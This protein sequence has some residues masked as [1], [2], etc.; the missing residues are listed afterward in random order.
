[1]HISTGFSVRIFIPTGEPDGLRVVEK[2]N[3][4]GQGLV[5]PK[6][7]F[8]DARQRPELQRTGV[9]IMW[10]PGETGQMPQAYIGE[11]D[12]VIERL[13]SHE[14]KKDFWTQAAV[15]TSKDQYLNKAHVQHLEARLVE[16][17]HEAKRCELTNGNQP[18][19]PALSD[20][21]RADA[22]SFLA[23]T[24]LCLPVVGVSFFDKP[25]FSRANPK[26]LFIKAKGV[27]AQGAEGTDGFIVRAGSRAVQTE[28]ES[29]P[30]HIR[31]LRQALIKQA[32]L[33]D[34]GEHFKVAQDY[35]FSSASTASSVL[36]GRA[37][38][39]RVD[40]KDAGGRTL[41]EIQEIE[42]DTMGS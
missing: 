26:G 9:Y 42:A 40:W 17:A 15:F 12:V 24:L 19:R 23:D 20:A 10:G 28:T 1:M 25:K 33:I 8:A 30:Q 38:N 35:A 16:L 5:V 36:L 29:C 18:Q 4:T 11:G 14:R 22:E 3:W 2:S 6:S 41:K 32:V 31:F 34:A 21:D 27:E 13:I 7:Q 39:G 37:S